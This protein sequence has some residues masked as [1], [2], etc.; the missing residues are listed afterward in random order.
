[1]VSCYHD[2]TCPYII[3]KITVDITLN[4]F[5]K[6]NKFIIIDIFLLDDNV[7]VTFFSQIKLTHSLSSRFHLNLMKNILCNQTII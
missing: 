3:K 4:N 5:V 1:M 2:T 6:V 7:G